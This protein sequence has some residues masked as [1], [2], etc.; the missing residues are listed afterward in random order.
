[1]LLSLSPVVLLAFLLNRGVQ[2]AD[3]R[4]VYTHYNL[5]SSKTHQS[6]PTVFYF[7]RFF[8]IFAEFYEFFAVAVI[9]HASCDSVDRK[10]GLTMGM[11][12]Y[13]NK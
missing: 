6:F 1:L 2:K 3:I 13:N 9:A 11:A 4:P 5:L 10:T 12:R 8:W 7:G